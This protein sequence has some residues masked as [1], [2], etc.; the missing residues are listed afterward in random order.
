MNMIN[1][2]NFW[3]NQTHSYNLQAKKK[4][5]K[6][7][8]NHSSCFCSWQNTLY[9]Q[10]SSNIQLMWMRVNQQWSP[11]V[12]SDS[13]GGDL[14]QG[15]VE[16]HQ[17][18]EQQHQQGDA[19]GERQLKQ[20]GQQFS[21]KVIQTNRIWF[22]WIKYD[23]GTWKLIYFNLNPGLFYNFAFIFKSLIHVVQRMHIKWKY[24]VA[25]FIDKLDKW[26]ET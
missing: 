18:G 25:F 20:Q 14:S 5:N 15:G 12:T 26:N 9:R 2:S 13:G 16:G 22:Q 1:S 19:G 8:K 21:P 4:K 23:I 3:T 10:H 24:S 11:L 7:Q 17:D 6:K